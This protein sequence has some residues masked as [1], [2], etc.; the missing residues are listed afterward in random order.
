M[1]HISHNKTINMCFRKYWSKMEVNEEMEHIPYGEETLSFH[2][3]LK[4]NA[5]SFDRKL[6]RVW[7]T[8]II[9][10]IISSFNWENNEHSLKEKIVKDLSLSSFRLEGGGRWQQVK[11]V[12]TGW[13]SLKSI[14]CQLTFWRMYNCT[15]FS[16]DWGSSCWSQRGRDRSGRYDKKA[17]D[18]GGSSGG[19]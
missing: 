16:K 8:Y 11:R 2:E 12:G 18:G 19:E 14:L 4:G 9:M 7:P 13:K 6:E 3:A 5:A 10:H 17:G 15:C 1:V